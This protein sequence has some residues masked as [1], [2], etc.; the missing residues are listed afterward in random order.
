MERNKLIF[1]QP[2]FKD[3]HFRHWHHWGYCGYQDSFVAPIYQLNAD[4][5]YTVGESYPFI[6]IKDGY[7]ELGKDLYEGDI[8][9]KEMLEDK[10]WK[11]ILSPVVIA[12]S[13]TGLN[14]NVYPIKEE[15]KRWI[16]I[17]NIIENP[18]LLKEK[19]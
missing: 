14:W 7:L 1:R 6:G 13:E 15:G 11:P 3:K 17:G 12:W 10:E 5:G 9:I 8:V 16:A 19:N 4:S 2:F 18:E